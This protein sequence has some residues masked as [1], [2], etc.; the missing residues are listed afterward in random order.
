[1]EDNGVKPVVIVDYLQITRPLDNRVSTK[2]AVDSHVRAFKKLQVEND[3][4]VLLISSLNRSNYLTPVDFEAFKESGGI[5][6]TS[7]VL[8]GLQLS[9]MNDEMFDCVQCL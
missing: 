3:L 6:Y 2:D 9:V 4:I 5:E 8:W 7:D 1:M